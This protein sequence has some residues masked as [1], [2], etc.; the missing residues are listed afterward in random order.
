MSK[1][2]FRENKKKP[3]DNNHVC[4]AVSIPYGLKKQIQRIVLEHNIENVDYDDKMNISKIVTGLLK[5]WVKDN[6]SEQTGE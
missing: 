6:Y 5:R 4:F 2:L 3:D 1:N